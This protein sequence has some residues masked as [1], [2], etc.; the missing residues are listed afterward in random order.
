M[1]SKRLQIPRWVQ[2]QKTRKV[3]GRKKFGRRRR[4]GRARKL[5][6]VLTQD[7]KLERLRLVIYLYRSGVTSSDVGVAVGLSKQ[8]VLQL[9]RA[10]GMPRRREGNLAPRRDKIGRY[11]AVAA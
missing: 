4:T 10:A 9:L 11:A 5:T 8:R 3:A 6:K 2:S 1:A 7:E